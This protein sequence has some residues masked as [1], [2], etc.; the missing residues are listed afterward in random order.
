MNWQILLGVLSAVAAAGWNEVVTLLRTYDFW[1]KLNESELDDLSFNPAIAAAA[2][3][4]VK[5]KIDPVLVAD[6]VDAYAA[7][8]ERR[9]VLDASIAAINPLASRVVS[10]DNDGNV[11]LVNP[12]RHL[13]L[14]KSGT[15]AKVGESN[16]KRGSGRYAASWQVGYTYRLKPTW[17]KSGKLSSGYMVLNDDGTATMTLEWRGGLRESATIILPVKD[18]GE[19]DTERG[20]TKFGLY[21]LS[22]VSTFGE[23]AT[24]VDPRSSYWIGKAIPRERGTKESFQ[25]YMNYIVDNGFAFA[26]GFNVKDRLL[27]VPDNI[28]KAQPKPEA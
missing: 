20:G 25:D 22:N 23:S 21:F 28:V 18:N 3:A 10:V 11:V 17:Y 7:Y 9:A 8:M 16:I 2:V 5:D 6:L 15:K 27:V 13:G 4:D 14:E 24:N 1:D 26:G 19:I 12:R